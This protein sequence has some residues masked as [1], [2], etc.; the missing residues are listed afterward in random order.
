MLAALNLAVRAN[1]QCERY[2]KNLEIA[3]TDSEKSLEE[4]RG[5]LSTVEQ[6]EKEVEFNWA[7]VQKLTTSVDDAESNLKTLKIC[8]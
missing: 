1:I 7:I 4:C 3:T 8:M 2:L 5:K 6:P